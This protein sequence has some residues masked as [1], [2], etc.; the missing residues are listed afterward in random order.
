MVLRYLTDE[1]LDKITRIVDIL[2]FDE[3]EVIFREG[4]K[5]T[6]FHLLKRGKVVL[7]KR[8]SDKLSYAA[9][10]VK[11]GYSFGWSAMLEE[12]DYTLDA[13]AAEPCE[14][15]SIKGEKLKKLIEEDHT[16]GYIMTQG[17][18]RVLKRRLDNRTEQ[19]IRVL[20][21]HPDI[22]SLDEDQQVAS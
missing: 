17:L 10:S 12:G 9:G 2:N 3:R 14:V 22:K 15:Y 5:G 16:M 18:L 19:F 13:V 11:P 20:T 8:I 21:Q 6:R 4:D 1:M 7:E